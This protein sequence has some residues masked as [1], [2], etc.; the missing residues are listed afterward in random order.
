M[1]R[2]TR[3]PAPECL[4]NNAS[5]WGKEWE[6]RRRSNPNANFHWHQLNGQVVNQLILPV[7]KAQ[8]QDHCSFCDNYPVSP[9]SIETI[10]HFRPKSQFPLE[11]YT[12]TNLYFC[13]TYCQQKGTA[14]DDSLLQPDAIEYDFLRYFRWDFTTGLI[15]VNP[16]ASP[17]DKRRAAVTIKVYRLNEGHPSFRK[18]ALRQRA[19]MPDELLDDF[20]YRDYVAGLG[21]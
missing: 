16:K 20:P 10:E 13:C 19:K 4:K 14:F 8:T 6:A 12:W 5:A 21:S 15:E 17:E 2:F 1:R 11:A 18:R 3:L 9:P 7:L